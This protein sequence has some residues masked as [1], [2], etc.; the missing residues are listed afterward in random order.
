M[1]KSSRG[2]IDSLA[3]ADSYYHLTVYDNGSVDLKLADC[4]RSINWGFGEPGDKRSIK[5]IER[6][7]SVVDALHAHLT[8]AE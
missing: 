3:N 7:K 8:K 6:I 5:K 2:F 4:F 1:L